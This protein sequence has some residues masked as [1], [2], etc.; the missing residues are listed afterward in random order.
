VTKS[1]RI[2]VTASAALLLASC[3]TPNNFDT[4]EAIRAVHATAEELATPK[5]VYFATTRCADKPTTGAPG[6]KEEMLSNR[7]WDAA[8]KN[9]EMLRLGFGL[10]GSD[11]VHCGS[12]TVAVMPSNADEKAATTVGTPVSF[13]CAD[14]GVLR[15]AVLDTPCRCALVVITGFNT[16]FAFGVK[17]AAQLSLD[18]SF[19]GV[20]VLFSFPAAGRLGDYVNDTEAEELAAPALNRLLVALSRADAAGTPAVDV[21]AH[22][23]GTRLALRAIDERDAPSLRYVVLAAPDIDPA[24]FLQLASKATA[25][26]RRLTVYTSKFDVAMSASASLH[27]GR[28]R[29]GEGLSGSVA[30]GLSGTE[31]VDATERA[32]DPYA[33][34]YFAESKVMVEDMRQSLSG[35]PAT[36]RKPLICDP[37]TPQSVIVCKMPCPEGAKCGP[38]WYARFVHWLLD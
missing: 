14:F 22:S 20:P 34:S 32:T 21:I 37:S 3:A 28:P 27:N 30:R 15:Q 11:E 36:E 16:T 23:M 33:H 5:T 38:S 12:A 26:A 7:C 2:A 24:A 29:V 1:I 25:H 19:Q 13:E 17:R 8:L 35:K 9:E 4:G 10:T 31:I 6:S 18:L